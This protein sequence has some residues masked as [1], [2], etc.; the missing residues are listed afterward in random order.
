MKKTL[1]LF[2]LAILSLISCNTGEEWATYKDITIQGA[3]NQEDALRLALNSQK[4]SGDVYVSVA[5]VSDFGY[6]NLYLKYTITQNGKLIEENILSINL[7]D[8]AG[9]WSGEKK[10]DQYTVHQK[11]GTYDL[12]QPLSIEIQ[13]HSREEKLEGIVSIGVGA[14]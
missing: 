12:S 8:G 14:K 13:Q 11:L 3:W 6:E 2:C 1:L 7:M 9:L 4:E 10:N 5:H